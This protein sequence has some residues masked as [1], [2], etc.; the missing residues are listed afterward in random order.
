MIHR[1]F[2][3]YVALA[4]GF[5]SPATADTADV[6]AAED[7]GFPGSLSMNAGF[8]TDYAFRGV[9]QTKESYALQGGVD[10][11]H[12][13]GLFLGFW[14]S[15]VNFGSGDDSYMEQDFYGGYAGSLGALSYDIGVYYFYYPRNGALNY[16]EYAVNTGY[17]LGFA[18]L[19]LG[20]LYSPDYLALVDD[21]IYVSTGFEYPLP[22]EMPYGLS[23][24]LD[25]NV[26]LT[27]AQ[28]PI[29]SDDDYTDWNVGLIVG[30]P[31]GLSLDLRYVDT[32]E[33]I[34]IA[35]SRFI[36][37]LGVGIDF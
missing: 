29:F 19:K 35:D 13:S 2:P 34:D 3:L 5:A 32:D 24:T 23:L 1:W 4:L 22:I 27:K 33:D 17:D 26:G 8:F 15:R 10:W 11:S 12:D 21:A 37:G 31:R 16:W 20:L 18:S 9:S 30:L 36:V 7:E 14:G 25:A 28:D 6:A